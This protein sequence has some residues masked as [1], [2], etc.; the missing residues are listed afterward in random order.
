[1]ATPS[2]GVAR[3]L[4]SGKVYRQ[5]FDDEVSLVRSLGA[6]RSK[7]AQQKAVPPPPG[8]VPL[9][10]DPDACSGHG[11]LSQRQQDW[12][13]GMPNDDRIENPVLCREAAALAFRRNQEGDNVVAAREVRGLAEVVIPEKKHSDILERLSESRKRRFEGGLAALRQDLAQVGKELERCLVEPGKQFLANLSAS[14]QSIERL[15]QRLADDAALQAYTIQDFEEIWG[16]ASRETLQRQQWLRDLEEALLRAERD[17]AERIKLLL[18]KYTQILEDVAYLLKADVHRLVHKEAMTINQALLANRR[19]IARL[20]RNLA[21]ADLKRE[22]AQHRRMEERRRTWKALQKEAVVAAFREFMGSERIQNPAAVET[23]LQQM[24]KEQ[25]A[26][27]EERRALLWSLSDLLPL[28]PSKAKVN[29]WYE[30]LVALNK[31]IDTHNVQFMMRIRIQYEKICQECLSKVQEAKQKLLKMKVCTEEEAERVV[32]PDFFQ[33]VGRLQSRFEAEVEKMDSD[34]ERLA[35]HT[36]VNCRHLSQFFQEALILRDTHRQRLLRLEEELHARMNEGRL[37]HESL[38]KLREGHLDV[39]VDRLRVQSSDEKLKAQLEKVHAALDFIRAGYVVFH[40][41]LC[42]CASTYPDHVQRELCSYSTS[43]S[44]YFHLRDVFRGKPVRR[45]VSAAEEEAEPAGNVEGGGGGEGG[46]EDDGGGGGG[47]EKE[48]E[49]EPGSGEERKQEEEE[50]DGGGGEAAHSSAKEEEEEEEEGS[51]PESEGSPGNVREEGGTGAEEPAPPPPPPSEGS[52]QEEEGEEEEEEGSSFSTSRGNTYRVNLRLRKSQIR[53]PEKYFAGKLKGQLLPAYLEQA[54][55]SEAFVAELRRRVRLQFFEHLEAW[56]AE[57]TAQAEAV[58]AAKKEELQSELQLRLHLHEPR[59]GRIEKDVFHLR[60]AELRLHSERLVRH[61]AGVV[62]AL[63]KERGAFLRLRDEQNQLSRTFRLRIQDMENVFLTESRA[64]RLVHLSNNLHVELLNHVE[65]MQV[66]L[67]SYRYYLEEA[68]GKLREANTEFLRSCRLF[69]NGGNFSPEELESFMKR[70]QKESGRIDYAEGLIMIDMEK[71]ESS[72][73]EQATEVISKFD[74]RF[75]FL[76]MD[77]VFMDKIQRFLTN[78]QVKIKAEVAKSNLQTQTLNGLLEKLL[79][80][81]D[82]CLHPNVDKET[83][84]PEGL[85]DFAKSVMEEL[86]QRSKYLNCLLLPPPPPDP[87]AS[88]P[89]RG[90]VSVSLQSEE[91]RVEAPPMVMGVERTALM[92]PSRMGRPALEDP[93]L[94]LIKHLGG[95]QRLRKAGDSPPERDSPSAEGAGLSPPR[96]RGGR[97]NSL[98]PGP[99]HLPPK[100]SSSGPR[101]LSRSSSSIQK[102]IRVTKADRKLQIFGD[103]PKENDNEHFKGIIFTILWENFD[104][105]MILAEDFYKKEK[106]QITRPEFLQD[107][108]EQCIEV[109]GQKL[110]HY[111]QQTDEFH[112]AS[113]SEFREQLR[114]FEE[115]LPAVARLLL[116]R[117]LRDHEQQLSEAAEQLRRQLQ[118]QLQ[119]WD[120]AKGTSGLPPSL[121]LLPGPDQGQAV[122]HAGPPAQPPA[123]GGLVAGG[124]RAAAEPGPEHLPL[125][126]AAGGLGHRL[127]PALRPGLVLLH[128]EDP[129][130]PG[131]EPDHGRRGAGQSGGPAGEDQHAPAA[132]EGRPVLGGRGGAPGGRARGQDVAGPPQDHPGGAAQPDPLARDGPRHHRQDHAGTRGRPGGEGRRLREVQAGAGGGVCADPGGE[133]GPPA[134][135]PALGRLVAQVGPEDQAALRPLTHAA[136]ADSGKKYIRWRNDGSVLLWGGGGSE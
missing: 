66:S 111:Q 21:E 105:L 101:R 120:A 75:R 36:E 32:N 74:N 1:M 104:T 109:L 72:Y 63:H 29:E 69:S 92:L 115:C 113:I 131:P 43:L 127:C 85:Y 62:E 96:A 90:S 128:R 18:A 70:L 9:V 126:P 89:R 94:P 53:K 71:M 35:K 54:Y 130:G 135:G 107:T 76:T 14:D 3:V 30:S 42:A 24:R 45:I 86:K 78:I 133:H 15:F 124:G 47:E 106:H 93:A 81:I 136:H 97:S 58:T 39:S 57:Q 37:K 84:T 2:V 10:R 19:A 17:R 7:R 26:L 79:L 44:R 132:Q 119:M 16:L 41:D 123:A 46:R 49:V 64:D 134:E 114:C 11:F 23:E 38:N 6:S 12:V 108:F 56:F 48:A 116:G 83:V 8:A 73:L 110:L 77:R 52:E 25:L 60:A 13:Q 112:V 91:G 61:C 80:R 129:G 5:V 28:P 33:W 59:R 95:F 50:K 67:R 40:Q 82:A 34:L 87:A 99:P 20:V 125:H 51:A 117:L 122:P 103:K 121:P 100:K 22:A 118:A 102:Y 55:L 4:P 68:F 27:T 88:W 31:R 65:V 98:Q